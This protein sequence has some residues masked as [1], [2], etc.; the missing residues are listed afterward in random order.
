MTFAQLE[1]ESDQVAFGLERIGISRGM[2]TILMVP[3][4]MDFF[5]VIFAM[6]KVGAVPVVVDPGMGH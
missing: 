6:F 2:R 5:I 1:K 3:P 4:R